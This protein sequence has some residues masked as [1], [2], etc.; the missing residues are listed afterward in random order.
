MEELSCRPYLIYDDVVTS[1]ANAD[2]R[3]H[4]VRSSIYAASNSLD[5]ERSSDEMV[6]QKKTK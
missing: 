1:T 6:K 4:G 2:I 3:S 5:S